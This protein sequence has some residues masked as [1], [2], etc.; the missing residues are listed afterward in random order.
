MRVFRLKRVIGM[1]ERIELLLFKHNGY[2]FVRAYIILYLFSPALNAYVDHVSRQ[3]LKA[4]L[5]AFYIAQIVYRFYNYGG[6]YAGGY[7]PLSFMGLYTLARY[8][9]LYPNKYT[10]YSIYRFLP[11]YNHIVF[12]GSVLSYHYIHF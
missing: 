12:H 9:R 7:S 8:M 10:K 5:I 4:F 2:W 11:I 1:N 6:W 3:H